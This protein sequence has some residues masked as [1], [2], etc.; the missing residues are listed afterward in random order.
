MK[1][2]NTMH[3]IISSLDKNL[4]GSYKGYN[5]KLMIAFCDGSIKRAEKIVIKHNKQIDFKRITKNSRTFARHLYE[6]Y[7]LKMS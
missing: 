5:K 7:F 2:F 4:L 6:T 3:E 1:K